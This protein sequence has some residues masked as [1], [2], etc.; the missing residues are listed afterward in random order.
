MVRRAFLEDAAARTGGGFPFPARALAVLSLLAAALG[1]GSPR[2]EA[3]TQP[4][5]T[6]QVSSSRF[7]LTISW[8][9]QWRAEVIDQDDGKDWVVLVSGEADLTLWAAPAFGGDGP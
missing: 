5:D 3:A 1:L 6:T 9:D 8:G 7:G 2:A 4:D